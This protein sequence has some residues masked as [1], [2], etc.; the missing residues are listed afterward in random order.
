MVYAISVHE[1]TYQID[2]AIDENNSLWMREISQDKNSKNL[3]E[4]CKSIENIVYITVFDKIIILVTLLGEIYGYETSS[5]KELITLGRI[6]R[7]PYL[8]PTHTRKKSARK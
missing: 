3:F 7:L 4:L 6:N 2:F 8:I 1:Y 5:A